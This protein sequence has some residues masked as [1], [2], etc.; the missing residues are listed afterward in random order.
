MEERFMAGAAVQ[1]ERRAAPPLLKVIARGIALLTLT[2]AVLSLL[3]IGFAYL[4]GRPTAIGFYALGAILLGTATVGGGV[5]PEHY[6]WF[7][8]GDGGPSPGAVSLSAAGLFLV[9][10]GAMIAIAVL[11]DAL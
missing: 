8:Y 9:L 2:L 4:I 6:G 11:I 7:L 3:A 10:G 5:S 1:P